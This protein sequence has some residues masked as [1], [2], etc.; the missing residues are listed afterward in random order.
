[1]SPLAASLA[2]YGE[3]HRDRRNVATHLVGIPMIF[4]A[5]VIL[6]SRPAGSVGGVAVSPAMLASLTAALF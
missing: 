6:L 4:L 2:R 1:M 5:V 3:Y